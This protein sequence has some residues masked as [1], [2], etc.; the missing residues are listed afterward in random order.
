MYLLTTAPGVSVATIALFCC[1]MLRL[2]MFSHAA[3]KRLRGPSAPRFSGDKMEFADFAHAAFAYFRRN[4]KSD[5]L[6]T[7]KRPPKVHSK[8][9][10]KG[11]L[12]EVWNYPHGLAGQRLLI[13]GRCR[14]NATPA[15][16]PASR[17]TSRQSA[18]ALPFCGTEI[19]CRP[20]SRARRMNCP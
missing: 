8:A 11:K 6:T 13:A 19:C 16:D 9:Y 7:Q 1:R 4:K 12:L 20:A 10:H 14:Q 17:R 2:V 5:M 15:P 18:R 3:D